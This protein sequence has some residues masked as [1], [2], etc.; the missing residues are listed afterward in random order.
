MTKKKHK[1]QPRGKKRCKKAPRRSMEL[2]FDFSGGECN[3]SYI[4]TAQVTLG[5]D[6]GAAVS[7]SSDGCSQTRSSVS[8]NETGLSTSASQSP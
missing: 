1:K 3:K 2:L 4:K 8:S 7:V 6:A 5:Y